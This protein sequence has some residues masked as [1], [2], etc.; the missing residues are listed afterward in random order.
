[1]LTRAGLDRAALTQQYRENRARS[2]QIFRSFIAPDAYEKQPIV[3]RHPFVFYDGHIP[4]FTYNKLI[5]EA[6][7]KPSL[8][9]EFEVLFERGIDPSS[10]DEAK[11]HA[12]SAWPERAHVE[13]YGNAVE[14]AVN[15][16][17]A[18]ATLE[19]STNPYLDRAQAVFNI[20]EHERMHHETLLY[21]VNQ[22][23]DAHKNA[24]AGIVHTDSG[25][26][27]FGAPVEIAA[28]P[29]TLGARR[30]ALPFGWDNEFD[31]HRVEVGRFAIDRHNVTNAEYLCFVADGGPVPAFWVERD[32][33]WMLRTVFETIALPLSWP[34]YA[35]NDNAAAFARWSQARLMTEA[36]YH[37]AAFGTPGGEERAHPWGDA[38]PTMQHGNFG[39]KRF[40]P[41]PIGSSPAGASAWG[42]HDLVGNG[43]EWTAT[44]FAPFVGFEP[45]ATYQPYSRSF[46]DNEHFVLKGAAPVTHAGLVRRSLRNWFYRDYPYMF[47][48][49]R[50]AYDR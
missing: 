14:A 34:V 5:K 27:T 46:F 47:A 15:D 38:A 1:M 31:E 33:R 45:M 25:G 40:D 49:F 42:V 48:T 19:D 12:K 43:W 16:A 2:T 3:L 18:N 32:G 30:D 8:N 4:A 7:G 9:A 50:R 24:P 17:L 36:E 11:K 20:I 37:R 23:D 22:L 39:F 13:A 10:A 26:P 21:I 28:G 44:P 35:S 6:L 29:A 41:E